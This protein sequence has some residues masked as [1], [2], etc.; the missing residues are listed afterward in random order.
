MAAKLDDEYLMIKKRLS[1][2]KSHSSASTEEDIIVLMSR[3]SRLEKQLHNEA[4]NLLNL[5][6]DNTEQLR[7]IYATI[8]ETE[9][10]H[11]E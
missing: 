3:I 11:E 9:R 8:K 2:K 7:K 10:K 6:Y 5:Q 1:Q 4:T